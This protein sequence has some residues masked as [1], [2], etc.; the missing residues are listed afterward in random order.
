MYNFQIKQFINECVGN[1]FNECMQ[2][3][4]I[5]QIVR[6]ELE[7]ELI[8]EKK[9]KRKSANTKERQDR[10]FYNDKYVKKSSIAYKTFPNMTKD[11]ARSA[12]SKLLSDKNKDPRQPSEDVIDKVHNIQG[13]VKA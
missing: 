13:Q 3:E 8:S 12:L 1:A 9:G 5:K 10:N 4:R 11:A 6:E 2:R 7:R